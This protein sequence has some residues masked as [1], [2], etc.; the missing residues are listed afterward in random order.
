MGKDSSRN[1]GCVI[2]I[3]NIKIIVKLQKNIS[4]VT[5]LVS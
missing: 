5:K 4:I 3:N 1:N 2:F